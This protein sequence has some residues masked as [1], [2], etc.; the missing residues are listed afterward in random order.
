MDTLKKKIEDAENYAKTLPPS[1]EL[2]MV[3][4]K[5]EEA[6]LWLTNLEDPAKPNEASATPK[7]PDNSVEA[8]PL[9]P[10]IG[11]EHN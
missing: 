5:L 3:K 4:T 7:M 11:V 1:R 8:E 2:S 9:P 10:Y 6:R